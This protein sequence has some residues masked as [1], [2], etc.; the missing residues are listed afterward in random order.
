MVEET[1]KKNGEAKTATSKYG[2]VE[3]N[4]AVQ[5]NT[6]V[7]KEAKTQSVPPAAA[8]PQHTVVTGTAQERTK[9]SESRVNACDE[10]NAYS[11]LPVAMAVPI[12]CPEPSAPPAP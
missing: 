4:S 3:Q 7:V 11:D 2:T 1:P 10:E 8:F 12:P 6:P 9:Q 5:P